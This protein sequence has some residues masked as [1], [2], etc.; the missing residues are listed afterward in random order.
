MALAAARIQ[1]LRDRWAVDQTE[2]GRAADASGA[3]AVLR[4]VKPS[5][6]GWP[7]PRQGCVNWSSR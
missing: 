4:I 1:H 7:M 3:A 6:S 5:I 2:H